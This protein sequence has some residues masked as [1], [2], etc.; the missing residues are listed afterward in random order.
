MEK[1]H[2]IDKMDF[3]FFSFLE[4]LLVGWLFGYCEEHFLK[5]CHWENLP[6]FRRLV[7]K[8]DKV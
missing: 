2:E 3:S 7:G 5:E 4:G 1:L 6:T 8:K